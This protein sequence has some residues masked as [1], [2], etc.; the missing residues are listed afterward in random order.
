MEEKNTLAYCYAA[1]ITTVKSFMVQAPNPI[2]LT[3][4]ANIGQ[5]QESLPVTNNLSHYF[6]IDSSKTRRRTPR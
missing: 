6:D 4:H 1:T 3:L 2:G 5:G